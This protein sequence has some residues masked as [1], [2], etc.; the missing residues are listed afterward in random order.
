MEA[1][2]M[3]HLSRGTEHFWQATRCPQGMK[4]MLMSQSM[5]TLQSFSLWSFSS[6]VTGSSVENMYSTNTTLK[7]YQNKVVL[8]LFILWSLK[9]VNFLNVWRTIFKSMIYARNN[10]IFQNLQYIS[11]KACNDWQLWHLKEYYGKVIANLFTS[12]EKWSPPH[13]PKYV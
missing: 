11:S 12:P 8:C 3:G 9:A 6:F 4:T 5:Q 13:S 1:Q 2:Q 10:F 7:Q